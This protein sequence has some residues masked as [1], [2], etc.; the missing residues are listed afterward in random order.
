MPKLLHPISYLF[1][2]ADIRLKIP[3]HIFSAEFSLEA[4][5]KLRSTWVPHV[6]AKA[7]ARLNDDKRCYFMPL[8]HGTFSILYDRIRDLLLNQLSCEKFRNAQ[9]RCSSTE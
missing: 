7:L 3:M 6:I 8:Q 2:F 1:H 9:R 5:V 4:T